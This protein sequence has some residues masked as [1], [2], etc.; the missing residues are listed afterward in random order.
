MTYSQCQND[1]KQIK[2]IMEE[3]PKIKLE[4]TIADKIFEVF[5]WLL[6][7]AVWFLTIT[8]YANLTDTI[9]THYNGEGQVDKY[10]G[11]ATI[12]ILPIITTILFIGMT[13]L[14][15]YPHVFNYPTNISQDN[16]LR[17][18]T[19]ATR[20]IRYLK[21]IIVFIFGLITFKIIQNANGE[22]NGLGIW[23]LPLTMGLI[24]I[25]L[26]YFVKLSKGKQ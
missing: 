5:G 11:K 4:F 26:I 23:F 19:N 10:G 1:N 17:H 22:T 3:R 13:V 7:V 24:F 6:I 14:N 16:A 15:K 18:Y 25:P 21:I 9:P 12:L 20:L 8:N 2:M